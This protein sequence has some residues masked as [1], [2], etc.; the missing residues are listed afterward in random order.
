MGAL[1]AWSAAPSYSVS[2]F[3]VTSPVPHAPWYD[4]W[5]DGA[6]MYADVPS[7]YSVVAHCVYS[8]DGSAGTRTWFRVAVGT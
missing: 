3:P 2:V 5:V 6:T 1:D 4:V 7:T 8:P